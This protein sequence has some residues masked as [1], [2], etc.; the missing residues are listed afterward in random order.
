MDFAAVG[1]EYFAGGVSG[2]DVCAR[3]P[4]KHGTRRTCGRDARAPTVN[5]R[6]YQ[7][8][9]SHLVCRETMKVV[10]FASVA[11]PLPVSHGLYE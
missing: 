2:F 9:L 1:S 6:H 7:L 4:A 5:L 10:V 11:K 8:L 3:G